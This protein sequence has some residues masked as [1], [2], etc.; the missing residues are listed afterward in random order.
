[1]G[2]GPSPVPRG[3]SR[4]PAG[5]RNASDGD[6]PGP[7]HGRKALGLCPVSP[8][9]APG[10]HVRVLEPGPGPALAAQGGRGE[11]DLVEA[12]L[13]W[14]QPHG[15]SPGSSRDGH[16]GSNRRKRHTG[17]Y[18]GAEPGWEGRKEGGRGPPAPL[19]GGPQPRT[20]G[21]PSLA[22]AASRRRC[23]GSR[24]GGRAD[25]TRQHGGRRADMAGGGSGAGVRRAALP[26]GLGQPG[27]EAAAALVRP[28]Q[29]GGVCALGGVLRPGLGLRV[30]LV[31]LAGR[32]PRRLRAL[33]AAPVPARH[34]LRGLRAPLHRL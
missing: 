16:R 7:G 19:P 22:T 11:R 34:H 25:V 33:R 1:M 12:E 20:G 10:P 26:P 4:A 23:L 21:P 14:G 30:V 5:S 15:V 2:R 17:G 32:A 31:A 24:G 3:S 9:D 13:P 8:E 29:G 27:R 6:E 18:G 28:G